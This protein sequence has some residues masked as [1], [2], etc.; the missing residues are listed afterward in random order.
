MWWAYAF[1]G[2]NK[3]APFA[4]TFMG[5]RLSVRRPAA[6]MELR[7]HNGGQ[8]L[9]LTVTGRLEA[10]ALVDGLDRALRN[11]KGA[12]VLLLDLHGAQELDHLALSAVLVVLKNHASRF[13][14][15]ELD[16]LPPWARLRVYQSGAQGLLGQGWREVYDGGR[17]EF[18]RG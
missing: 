1:A 9:A 17:L 14:R 5:Q 11:P 2:A 10:M 6:S 7:A 4:A 3:T 13:Q 8:T 16:G 15:L 18:R 12:E